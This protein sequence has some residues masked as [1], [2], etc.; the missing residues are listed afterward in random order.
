MVDR[1]EP[2]DI[3]VSLALLRPNK[4]VYPPYLLLAINSSYSKHQFNSRLKGIGVKN[5]HLKEIKNIIIP[6]PSIKEQKIISEIL[7]K[8]Q[9]LISKRKS[10]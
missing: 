3:Y 8:A 7:N 5:L 4:K 1:D 2:F 9:E 6:V 10:K